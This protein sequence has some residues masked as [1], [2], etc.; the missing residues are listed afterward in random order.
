[1][2]RTVLFDFKDCRVAVGE[3]ITISRGKV[4]ILMSK[5]EIES[6]YKELAPTALAERP[7]HKDEP[8]K[9]S[10]EDLANRKAESTPSASI[11]AK[12]LKIT[13]GKSKGVPSS[14]DFEVI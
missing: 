5:D 1:M 10:H 7:I 6:I 2:A 3:I 8:S 12:K 4:K 11:D 9:Y 13:S 14:P